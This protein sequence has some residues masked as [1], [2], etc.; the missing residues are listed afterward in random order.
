MYNK[1][2]FQYLISFILIAICS[3][4]AQSQP[5]ITGTPFIRNF[6]TQ[7]YQAGIQNWDLAQDARGVLYIA[8]NFGLLEFDG[9][10]W[11]VYR[12]KNGSK[13][14]SLATDQSGKIYVGC[15][16]DFGYFFPNPSGA[17]VYTSLADSLPNAFRNF[18]E[19]WNLY[20]D[21]ERK[22]FCTF[23]NIFIFEQGRTQVIEPNYPL[24]LSFF[25]NRELLVDQR[26]FGLS[27]L[28][29]DSLMLLSDGDFFAQRRISSVLSS[30]HNQYLISTY[31]DGIYVYSTTGVS[32]WESPLQ[33]NFKRDIVNVMIRLRNGNYAI[34]TQNNGLYIVDAQGKLLR[35]FTTEGGLENRTV[36][37]LLEDDN[38]NLWV[39][40]NNG[41]SYIE[42]G[43]PFSYLNET[44]G[45]TGTGYAAFL[46]NSRL[47][48]GTNTGLF[49]KDINDL[50]SRFRLVEGSQGQVYHIG[51]Y[52]Q[53]L[54]MGH[55]GGTFRIDGMQ[56]TLLSNEPGGWIYQVSQT[57]PNYLIGG[58]YSGL[59]L[60]KKQNNHWVFERKIEGFSESSRVM[61]QDRDGNLWITHGYKG[62]FRIRNLFD[63]QSEVAFYGVNKGFPSNMLINV[64][65]VRNELIF[66]SENGVYKYNASTDRFEPDTFFSNVFGEEVQ[67]W[68]VQEDA[69][70]RIYFVGRDIIGYLHKT[71]SGEYIREIAHFN[72]IRR[73]LNDDLESIHIL[74]NHEVLFGA[75]E[76]FVLF[77]PNVK[78]ERNGSFNTLIRK[79]AIISSR[80]SVLFQGNFTRENTV[81]GNQPADMVHSLPYTL[82]SVSF[83]YAATS[84]ESDEAAMH[85]Y[86]LEPFEN[87]WSDWVATTEKEYTNLREGNYTFHVRSKNMLGEVSLESRFNFSVLPPWYRTRWAYLGYLVLT[88][89]LL[90]AFVFFIDKRHQRARQVLEKQQQEELMRKESEMVMLSQQSRQ[91]ISR[92]KNEKLEAELSHKTKELATSTVHILN[93]NEFI[94][95]LKQHIHAVARKTEQQ[96]VVRELNKLTGEIDSNLASDD[97]WQNFLIHFDNVHGDF[98]KR[99]RMAFP[100]LSPQEMKLCTYLRMNL[101]T[102]EIANLLTISVRGVEISRYRLRKKLALDRST[103]LQEYIL[104]F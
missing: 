35:H 48:L 103:N 67:L 34:G 39:G 66:T 40:L 100:N 17:L 64:Y 78:P 3:V 51:R 16:G 46:D 18:D 12:V 7:Q 50:S 29:G 87:N 28:S 81:I 15:Q 80:D 56:A 90:F 76:G 95:H 61:E 65:K 96:E 54:I 11:A 77:D 47:Y 101:S 86:Y 2:L 4:S 60:F 22:Y 74:N 43:S 10:N 33:E 63:T 41:L 57:N 72:V 104:N 23:S 27:K 55:H 30:L 71:V 91:E 98:S 36:L 88:S 42:L 5:R 99:F 73:Y 85:Q 49:V 52:G 97:D 79:F 1:L 102:K 59:Q 20:L 70:G 75:K 69:L 13:M 19:T 89:G 82:N 31:S 21:G 53:D 38:Q 62:V 32:I 93:K 25:V 6:S 68:K 58:V 92:L 83:A 44:S 37:N 8:N 24:E 14:R 45:L 94:S 84:F 9:S 26:G